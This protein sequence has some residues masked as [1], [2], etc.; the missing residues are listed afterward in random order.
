KPPVANAT[1]IVGSLNSFGKASENAAFHRQLTLAAPL[2]CSFPLACG[3]RVTA[4]KGDL[5]RQEVSAR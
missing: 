5:C 1:I 2:R 3:C 4:A